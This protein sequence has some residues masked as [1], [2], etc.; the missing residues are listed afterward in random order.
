MAAS[1]ADFFRKYVFA[2]L[3]FKLVSLAIAV[4]LWWAVGR[5]QPIE[6]PVTVPLEFQHAPANLDIN[7]D[8]PLQARVTLRGP[9]RLLHGMNPSQVHAVLDLRGAT[10]GERTFDLTAQDIGAPRS[11]KVVQIVPSQFH[12]SF[13][14]SAT[15]TVRVQPRVI[16]TLLSGYGITRVSAEPANITIVGP[17][18]RVDE[19][20]T[21]LTD[22]V[23]A[24]GVM[25]S[26]TFITHAYVSDPLVRVQTP[27]PIHVTVSTEKIS[28]GRTNLEQRHK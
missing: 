28:E 25:G 17:E 19:I 18:K 4:L 14:R 27:Q 5:D 6:I 1:L 15:R 20:Q 13:D 9:E 2:N 23:D 12:I 10:P 3:P 8:Y 7:S 22:P 11:V 26:G 24:T 16:G 21:A